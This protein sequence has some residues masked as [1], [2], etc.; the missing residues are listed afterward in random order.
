MPK[1]LAFTS[2]GENAMME[3]IR[4][5]QPRPSKKQS[6]TSNNAVNACI[7]EL[8]ALVKVSNQLVT[9]LIQ[10]ERP[11]IDDCIDLLYAMPPNQ[12]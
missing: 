9:A 10:F 3:N 2:I 8:A 11:T 4:L 5:K 7:T 12:L 6:M 1:D